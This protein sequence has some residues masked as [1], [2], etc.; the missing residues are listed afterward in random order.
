MVSLVTLVLHFLSRHAT[1]ENSLVESLTCEA[2]MDIVRPSGVAIETFNS[3]D[4]A[5]V[6]MLFPEDNSGET[7]DNMFDI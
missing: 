5:I 2:V 4:E 6:D 1:A 7:F 3:A